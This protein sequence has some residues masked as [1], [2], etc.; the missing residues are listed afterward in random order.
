MTADMVKTWCAQGVEELAEFSASPGVQQANQ[1]LERLQQ[2]IA[3]LN[4]IAA[5]VYSRWIKGLTL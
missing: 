5:N 2:R 3:S 4:N 1:I